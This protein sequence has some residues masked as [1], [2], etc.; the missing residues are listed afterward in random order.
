MTGRDTPSPDSVLHLLEEAGIPEDPALVH[1]VRTIGA[2]GGQHAPDA[3]AELAQLMADGG[4]APRSR[5]NKRRIT[6][7]GG[8]LAVSMGAGMSGVAA[9]TLHLRAGL[10]EA[11]DSI[12]RFS[13]RND[14]DHAGDASTTL[15][16]GPAGRVPAVVAPPRRGGLDAPGM[17]G[18]GPGPAP[19][20]ASAP[21]IEASGPG[22]STGPGGIPGSA[23]SG[24]VSS[25]AVAGTG[26]GGSAAPAAAPV[27]S[28]MRHPAGAVVLTPTQG[29]GPAVPAG[30]PARQAVPGAKGTDVPKAGPGK[31]GHDRT[32]PGKAGHDRTGPVEA[33][34]DVTGPTRIGRDGTGQD[35]GEDEAEDTGRRQDGKVRTG[36]RDTVADK[37]Q[38]Q[39]PPAQPRM[40]WLRAPAGPPDTF[41]LVEAPVTWGPEEL[42]LF[43]AE[44]AVDPAAL[45]EDD[46]AADPWNGDVPAEDLPETDDPTVVQPADA[47][48]DPAVPEAPDEAVVPAAAPPRPAV[49]EA[50]TEAVVRPADVAPEATVPAVP[51]PTVAQPATR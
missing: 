33:G 36:D 44:T 42:V 15:A 47:L 19:G 3:S 45:P 11:V 5:R 37:Y 46:V 2:L 9:G 41:A 49:P 31:A 23:S 21:S 20:P 14:A 51:G 24:A 50:P 30:P 26:V 1:A 29:P 38:E 4:T 8:A 43:L 39:E 16:D 6:F 40:S 34:H 22:G 12:T 18:P 17:P 28:E 27:A 48:P 32:D 13:V 35:T 7:I 10:D 25:G